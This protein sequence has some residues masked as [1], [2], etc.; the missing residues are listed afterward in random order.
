[1]RIERANVFWAPRGIQKGLKNRWLLSSL[2]SVPVTWFGPIS[3][4]VENDI[5]VGTLKEQTGFCPAQIPIEGILWHLFSSASFQQV[6]SKAYFR[7]E[8]YIPAS[9][10]ERMTA[11]RVQV[12]VS[13]LHRL[14]PALWGED[15][16]LEFLRVR[17]LD[18]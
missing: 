12:E 1:M 7:V 2:P 10:I 5:P 14:S 16:E 13:E 18:S 8:D 6:E 9:L 4:M 17:P 3:N 15:A 11:L